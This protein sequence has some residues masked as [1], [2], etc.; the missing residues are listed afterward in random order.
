MKTRS[1]RETGRGQEQVKRYPV[2]SHAH[3][4]FLQEVEAQVL[5]VGVVS[6]V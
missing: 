3:S 2:S 4:G 1:M 5:L 6:P